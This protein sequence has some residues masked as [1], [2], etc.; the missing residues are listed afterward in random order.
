[1]NTR[2]RVTLGLT[3]I[4]ISLVMMAWYVG[5]VPDENR[6]ARQ[7]RGALAESIALHVTAMVLHDDIDQLTD[8]FR[9][10]ASRNP[11]LQSIG[12]R[13]NS[14]DL[15]A[16][17]GDHGAHWKS[18]PDEYSR[19]ARLQVPI[20]NGKEQWG[21]LELRFK[22]PDAHGLPVWLTSP[23]MRTLL[24]LGLG[25]FALFYFYLGKVLR[26]LDPS[27]A[28]PSRVR[29]ALDTMAEG[30]LVLDRKEQIVL[31]NQAFAKLLDQ[32]P[33]AL[34]GFKAGD[35][36]WRDMRGHPVTAA[37]LPWTRALSTGEIQRNRMLRLHHAEGRWRT[38]NINCSP[39]LGNGNKHAGV[40]ISFDDVTVLEHKEIE[41]RKSKEE[42]ESAN[43][44]KSAFLANMSHEI[45]TP[46]NAIIGFTEIL[47]RG[48]VQ[49]QRESLRYLD[50]I[51]ASG[52]S[53]LD[54]IN[55][56]LDLSKVEA[57]KMEIEKIR[58]EPFKLF[59]ETLRILRVK[60]DEKGIGLEFRALTPLPETIETDPTRLRQIIINLVGN[61]IKF[62]DQGQVAVE[63]SLL[64]DTG[65]PA[66]RLDIIDTG[67]GMDRDRLD[68]IFDPFTQADQSTTRKFG[69]TGLGLT[70]SKMFAE[71]LGGD[72]AVDSEPGKGSRFSVTID[73]G[74][75]TGVPR[76]EPEAFEASA[77]SATTETRE[78]WRFSGAR[79]LV[80]DDGEENRELVR[81]LLQD[82]G[83]EVDEAD[84]GQTG[85]E[86]AV[87]GDYDAILMDI[88]MPVM[89]GFTSVGKMRDAGVEDPVIALTANAM[90]G[91]AEE[92]LEAG[93]SG[94][95]SKPINIDRFLAMMA[96][97]LDGEQVEK[98]TRP[99]PPPATEPEISL[100]S[101]PI[102]SRL[103]ASNARFRDI[104]VKFIG[105]LDEQLEAMRS[106]WKEND[107]E[108]LAEL[109]H[110][111]KGAGGTVGFDAFTEPAEELEAAAKRGDTE[112]C[113]HRLKTLE[114]LAARLVNPEEEQEKEPV[115]ET[116]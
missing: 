110:W 35:L 97:L 109:A 45:R 32:P 21:R 75:L 77:A 41:L 37:D 62:T 72:I 93:F 68:S 92:C 79:I 106:A 56:I 6:L 24:F 7:A 16:E 51:S 20:W 4:L 19:R 114:S 53:L 42:A 8:D 83:A 116:G 10:I 17:F 82:A 73:P 63:A 52:K 71:A 96:G 88:H 95:F 60:A 101:E 34:I 90:K 87:A 22:A 5:V 14:G 11:D 80:V 33:D 64:D 115:A 76:L 15:L 67:I 38:F 40:L 29:A 105:R 91:F 28:V 99:A 25:S 23:L 49:N 36:P 78:G 27:N 107:L 94:Y 81:L 69:G 55:D 44:A 57:G 2:F 61:A 113:E 26:L 48:Y 103:P 84:N 65:A 31:A 12:L 111:L 86:R 54:L 3:S 85:Y 70:I 89:D 74:D 39:V 43:Q 1:M 102:H 104:I 47:K 98:P 66:L 58:C 18:L 50:I 30:L 112:G 13:R 108:T 59:D 46:M 9:F 100:A